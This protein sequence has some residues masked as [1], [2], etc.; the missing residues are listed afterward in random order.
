MAEPHLFTGA[1][2]GQAH[3]AESRFR[4]ACT[5]LLAACSLMVIL[6]LAWDIQWHGDVGPDTFFTAPHTLL[7]S[8]MGL[9]GIISL[10]VLIRT[11]RLYRAGA[12]AVTDATTTPWLGALRAPVGFLIAGL[13]AA[14]F[15]VSGLYDLLWHELY[16]FDV[17]LLSPPHFGLLFSGL[18]VM[19]GAIYSWASEANRGETGAVRTVD[20]GFA[21][22]MAILLAAVSA[23]QFIGLDDIQLAGPFI[24]Y[25]LMTAMIFPFGLVAALSFSRRFGMVTL[26]AVLFLAIRFVVGQFAP[27]ATGWLAASMEY[28]YREYA[29]RFPIVALT[30]P[31]WLPLMG[32]MIDLLTWAGRRLGM[33]WRLSA[34]LAASVATVV[35]TAVDQR[36][37]SYV[38]QVPWGTP[39]S[40]QR[41]LAQFAG[42]LGPP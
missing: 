7:Y 26:I 12:P 33:G 39:L 40:T 36:W 37:V 9:A 2:T 25:A 4:I 21:V 14:A 11:T 32:V 29:L 10:A 5:W 24:T 15:I 13:G 28:D 1:A 31:A 42:A 18:I 27:A 38:N 34:V 6:G 22:T 41:V 23:Y 35:Y 17:T 16:G 19:V 8:G 3:Q 20:V 30:L